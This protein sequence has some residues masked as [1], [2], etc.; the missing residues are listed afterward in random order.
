[1]TFKD[2]KI[3]SIAQISEQTLK[4]TCMTPQLEFFTTT[5]ENL[6]LSFVAL[7]VAQWP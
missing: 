5:E 3:F 7:P 1:M 2:I 6:L 4:S